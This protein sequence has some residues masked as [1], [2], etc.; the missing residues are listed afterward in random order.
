MALMTA[1]SEEA[2]QASVAAYAADVVGC[3]PDHILAVS[4]FEAGNRHA[5]FA[6]RYRQAS[7]AGH[8]V[9][10]RVAY[11][12]APEDR[13]QA[14]REAAVLEVMGGVAAPALYDFRRSSPWF[15]SSAMCIQFLAGHPRDLTSTGATDIERLGAALRSVHRR[16]TRDLREWLPS[17]GTVAS[18]AEARLD[19]ILAGVVWVRDPLPAGL[20]ARLRAA[21]EALARGFEASA[22]TPAFTTRAPL[23]LLHGDPAADNILWCP[24]PV[25]IDW[26]YARLGDPADELAYLFDQNGLTALQ[27]EAFWAGYQDS[28]TE[29]AQRVTCWEPVTLLGSALWWVERWV[30]RTDAD[31]VGRADAVAPREPTYYLDRILRRVDRLDRLM[32]QRT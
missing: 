28:S 18:Y 9:V 20:Q 25:L 10:V 22:R 24:D 14:Q 5:V 6:V 31:A 7:G 26:E 1:A 16:P 32:T 12:A 3:T 4:R 23:A 8:S 17:A 27:R 30:R 2:L 11:G 13:A 29:V 15:E 19:S 21:A